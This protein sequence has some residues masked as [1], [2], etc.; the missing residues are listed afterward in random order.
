MTTFL[1]QVAADLYER[2]GREVSSLRIMFPSRRARL[3]F[4]DALGRLSSG[5]L[6]LPHFVSIDDLMAEASGMKQGERV[7]LITELYNVY[8]RYHPDETFDKFYFWG[9]MLLNDF[10]SI[11]KYLVDADVLFANMAD[12]K[13]MESDYSYITEQQWQALSRFWSVIDQ[14]RMSVHKQ[15]F[16]KL[17]Q[18]LG[19]VYRDFR[20]Q[21]SELGIAYGGMI[22]RAAAERI[23][24]SDFE[25]DDGHERYVIAGFNALSACE[26]RLFDYLKVNRDAL[27]YWDY[28]D[29]YLEK[30][31]EAGLFIRDNLLRYPSAA[32]LRSRDACFAAGK[33][34]TAVAAASNVLQCKFVSRLFADDAAG[35]LPSDRNT[36]VVLTDENLLSPLL[37][38]IPD[39][40][41]HLNIT[42][43]FPVRQSVAYSFIERLIELQGR[44]TER[45]G[46][47][48]FYHSDVT[49]LLSHPYIEP[50][51]G[52]SGRELVRRIIDRQQVFVA[53]S[54]LNVTPLLESL[55]TLCGDWRE[56]S[57]YIVAMSGKVLSIM[58]SDE[59][60]SH[61]QEMEF[62]SVIADNVSMLRNSLEDCS[63]EIDLQVYRSLLRRHL[64]TVRIPFEGE[65]LQGLQV[66]G[67]LETRNLDFDNVVI[68]S[69]NDDN[70]PG[71]RSA[72][73]SFIPYALRAA[74]GLPTPEHHDG[75]YAYYFYRLIQRA[76]RV[77]MVY[78]SQ[79]D[80]N[81]NGEPSRYIR[82]L[83]YESGIELKRIDFGAD[84][85]LG[86]SA[87][88]VIAKR[89]DVA[90][91]LG[92]F[93]AEENP[94]PLS[95]TAFFR[96]VVCPM[97]FYF[98]SVVGIRAD[99][100]MVEEIDASMF[101]TILHYAMQLLY[102]P[103][104][105]KPDVARALASITGKD[106]AMAVDR[107]VNEKYLMR[108][109]VDEE[110]YGGQ[111]I[112]VR[113]I[114]CR[115]IERG[116]LAYDKA[117]P[118]FG[119][120]HLEYKVS[121][122]F[123]FESAGRRLRVLFEGKADRIDRL[124]SGRRRV[125]DYKTGV[126]HTE[127]KE[128]GTLFSDDNRREYSAVIQTLLYSMM[129]SHSEGCGVVPALY[130]V[131][132][133]GN[134][135]ASPDLVETFGGRDRSQHRHVLD[136]GA[137]AETFERGLA[138][139]LS[140]MFD[141][142]RPFVQCDDPKSCQYCDYSDICRRGQTKD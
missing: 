124:S 68:L 141:P 91:R 17:W 105:G 134:E 97:R 67:I 100:E 109:N 3:F 63:V 43:G 110:D 53:R 104:V 132:N 117:H 12:L 80:E 40:V 126:P 46:E 57:D 89:G 1:E 118:D 136:Y 66:M 58:S 103:L 6:W 26:K 72:S 70:F 95:P 25:L 56:L 2:F 23:A 93:V 11:D 64:Q 60:G 71:M 99:D 54:E 41:E 28:D 116:I 138:G 13:V 131:R 31:Q 108:E 21:L 113:D 87:P 15:A 127:F 120:E 48:H 62:L 52:D 55:F 8:R 9:D 115:Y 65:P 4:A 78:C 36:A 75:V 81:S 125:V 49:G 34:L 29:Y 44:S 7:R 37:Y 18:T 84:I 45:G 92:R 33:E 122:P 94:A 121:T 142:A 96:Y 20:A 106:I 73:S 83:D 140:E 30:G 88:L 74:Y 111:I 119:V 51:L 35:R 27:F 77:W 24:A 133:I 135:D 22:Q 130:Y 47:P 98:A 76:S 16:V 14:T 5:P 85:N 101:G 42:M 50:A 82:Q 123:E 139:V 39:S 90:E 102:E 69:M 79:N 32:D 137:G 38:S 86:E 112:L 129:L 59:G 107:A 19:P 114:I 10:D 128:F 61:K